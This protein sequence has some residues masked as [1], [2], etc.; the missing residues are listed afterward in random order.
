M[1]RPLPGAALRS[2]QDSSPSDVDGAQL[3]E[4]ER[5]LAFYRAQAAANA[6]DRQN[7]AQEIKRLK[8]RLAR[9]SSARRRFVQLGGL[10]L[11]LGLSLGAHPSFA[12]RPLALAVLGDSTPTVSAGALLSALRQDRDEARAALLEVQ[13]KLE[14][15]TREG[16][17]TS[18]QVADATRSE[19]VVPDHSGEPARARQARSARRRAARRAARARQRL[20]FDDSDDPLAGL[21]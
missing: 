6:R 14:Q 12:A 9:V 5:E 13:R 11:V 20:S 2:Q 1:V 4:T 21:R 18:G 3:Q 10:L 16:V 15:S 19:N 8:Q 17:A 7:Q